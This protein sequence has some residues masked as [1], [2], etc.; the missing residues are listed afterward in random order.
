MYTM[1][2]DLVTIAD[3]HIVRAIETVELTATVGIRGQIFTGMP[4]VMNQIVQRVIYGLG[5]AVKVQQ[6][7][8]VSV[9]AGGNICLIG[10]EGQTVGPEDAP[11]EVHKLLLGR[12]IVLLEGIV[13]KGIPEGRY[14]LSAAP[15]NLSGSDGAPC[16]AY[17]IEE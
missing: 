13:L 8:I 10:N 5:R 7:A 14:F 12:N 6:T 2:G 17:L 9:F 11:M 16:R 15:L 1:S 4:L 3:G